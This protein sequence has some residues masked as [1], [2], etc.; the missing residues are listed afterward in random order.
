MKLAT[1]IAALLLGIGVTTPAAAQSSTDANAFVRVGVTRIRLVDKGQIFINGALA[2]GA[3]Y[4]TPERWGAAAELGFF[5]LRNLSL[6]VA[7][8]SPVSTTNTPAGTLAGTPN[9]GSDRFSI[10][11][12]TAT[13]HPLRGRVLSPYLGGGIALQKVWS[14]HDALAAN[15]KVHDATGPVIQGGVEVRLADRFGLFVDAKKAFYTADA[16][17]DLG[18]AHITAAAKLDPLVL[19][20]GALFRF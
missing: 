2:P 8:T 1:S 6:Q 18:P 19:Q 12:A 10:F 11:T 14:T 9:L 5:V 20:A 17:G 15:L 7:G 16:S 3:G 4:R 13:F